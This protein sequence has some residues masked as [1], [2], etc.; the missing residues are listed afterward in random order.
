MIDGLRVLN[1]ASILAHV[2]W[3]TICVDY[4]TAVY[5][6]CVLYHRLE[7]GTLSQQSGCVRRSRL[8][9]GTQRDVLTAGDAPFVDLKLGSSCGQLLG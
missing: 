8:D 9:S 6:H 3:R 5:I 2:A 4:W 1:L 7:I